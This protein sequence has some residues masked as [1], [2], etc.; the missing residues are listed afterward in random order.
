MFYLFPIPN[1]TNPENERWG[2]SSVDPRRSVLQACRK[3]DKPETHHPFSPTVRRHT[4]PWL[5]F[6][7]FLLSSCIRPFLLLMGTQYRIQTKDV[8]V[9]WHALCTI[10]PPILFFPLKL[11]FRLLS[12]FHHRLSATNHL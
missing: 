12:S 11:Q 2:L 4:Y 1:N 7:C 6:A 5:A 10:F 9:F 8:F 3:K